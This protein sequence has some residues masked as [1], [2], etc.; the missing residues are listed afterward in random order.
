MS[1]IAAIEDAMIAALR[2][3]LPGVEVDTLPGPVEEAMR[4]TM[5]TPAV[6]VVYGGAKLQPNRAISNFVIQKVEYTFFVLLLSKNLRSLKE[7][8]RGA[9][10]LLE[11]ARVT[12]AGLETPGGVVSVNSEGLQQAEG[13]LFIYTV[14]VNVTDE[15]RKKL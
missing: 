4:R 13:G 15:F 5:R 1:T 14:T 7:G 9:Y 3:A 12:L 6:W 8:A 11:A 2:A 10:E